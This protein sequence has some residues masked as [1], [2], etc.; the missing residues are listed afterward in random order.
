[1]FYCFLICSSKVRIVYRF[2]FV[3]RLKMIMT[4]K[5]I[6]VNF[7]PTTMLFNL[8]QNYTSLKNSV[9]CEYKKIGDM[10]STTGVNKNDVYE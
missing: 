8:L 1:M 9:A 3:S 6:A 2:K 10:Y 7:K 5:D 4:D